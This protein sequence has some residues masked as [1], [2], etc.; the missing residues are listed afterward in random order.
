MKGP[1][2]TT[3]KIDSRVKSVGQPRI[4]TVN[5][6]VDFDEASHIYGELSRFVAPSDW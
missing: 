1:G 6:P 4:Y 3:K 5:F 2:T